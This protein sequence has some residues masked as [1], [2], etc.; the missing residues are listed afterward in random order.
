MFTPKALAWTPTVLHTKANCVLPAYL[1]V[2]GLNISAL[3]E[4]P[5]SAWQLRGAVPGGGTAGGGGTGQSALS[6]QQPGPRQLE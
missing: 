3:Q 6:V 4:R 2:L 1:A 5:A